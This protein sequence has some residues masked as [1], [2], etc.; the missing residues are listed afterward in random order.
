MKMKVLE[1]S[2]RCLALDTLRLKVQLV[3]LKKCFDIPNMQ[4]PLP[5]LELRQ[6]LG[7]DT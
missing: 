2:F 7:G 3:L 5:L 6:D 1:P 4:M